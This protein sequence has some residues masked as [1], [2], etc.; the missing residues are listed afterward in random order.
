MNWRD[1]GDNPMRVGDEDY[2]PFRPKRRRDEDGEL[3]R[4]EQEDDDESER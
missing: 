2:V 4:D 1:I 3:E